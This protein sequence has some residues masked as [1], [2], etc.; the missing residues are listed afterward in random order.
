MLCCAIWFY[1]PKVKSQGKSLQIPTPSLTPKTGQVLGT[2]Q[3]HN[4]P[5]TCISIVDSN[6]ILTSSWDKTVKKWNS[7]TFECLFTT[8]AHGDFVKT[9]KTYGDRFYSGSTDTTI[10]IWDLATG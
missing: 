8:E 7:K 1:L 5:V 2:F 9:C 4:G 6:H 3:G 10:G